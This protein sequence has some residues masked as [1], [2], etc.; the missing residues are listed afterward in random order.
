M[1]FINLSYYTPLP[2]TSIAK[3][4]W[5]ISLSKRRKTKKN[6]EIIREIWYN[7]FSR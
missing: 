6:A 3:Q 1:Q 7:K 5:A 4:K 2:A